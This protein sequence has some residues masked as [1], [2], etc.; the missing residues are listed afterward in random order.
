MINIKN[1]KGF[2]LIE[3]LVV[4]SIIALLSTLAVTA[5]GEARKK[6]RDATRI[7]NLERIQKALDIYFDENDVYPSRGITALGNDAV[8]Y[9]LG[10]SCLDN[11]PVGFETQEDCA[12]GAGEE[13]IIS[14]IP[15]DPSKPGILF[16][17]NAC[18]ANP[19]EP[20]NMVYQTSSPFSAYTIGFHLES[21]TDLADEGSY[22]I[23]E[24]RT[25]SPQ[26]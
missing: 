23:N 8:Q 11:S 5:L 17:A 12:I 14:I 4:I 13:K 16:P 15:E 2:T 18:V 25:V 7:A 26:L 24:D 20:C 1:K 10:T 22:F 6:A 3:L 9:T 21:N 19:S